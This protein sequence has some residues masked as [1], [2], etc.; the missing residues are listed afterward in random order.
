M[1][2]SVGSFLAYWINYACTRNVEKLGDW[3]WKTVQIFQLLAPIL[4]IITISF[5]PE[6]PRWLVKHD[7]MEEAVKALSQVRDDPERVQHEISDITRALQFEK[8]EISSGL[9]ALWKDKSI[10]KRLCKW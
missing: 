6:S 4:I 7:R 2:F 1:N 3:D 8:D 9:S 5:C 10:R